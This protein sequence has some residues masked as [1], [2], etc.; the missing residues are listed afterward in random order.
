MPGLFLCV[1]VFQTEGSTKIYEYIYLERVTWLW[2]NLMRQYSV[3]YL[4]L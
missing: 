3:I 1:C 2:K 4:K